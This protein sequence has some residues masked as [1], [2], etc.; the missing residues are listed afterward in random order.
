MRVLSE[1]NRRVLEN[2]K[3]V[4]VGYL[5]A[6]Y[7]TEEKFLEAID[8]CNNTKL[9]IFEI[10]LPSNNPHNDGEIIRRA[11]SA[12][13]CED[14]NEVELFKQVK[15]LTQKPIWIMAYHD[16]LI[17]TKK[18]ISLAE[19]GIVDAFVVPNMPLTARKK[20]KE[21]MEKYEVDVLGFTNPDMDSIEMADNFKSFA[22]IYEQLYSGITGSSNDVQEYSH[23]LEMSLKETN[24]V[25]FAGFGINTKEKAKKLIEQGF[26]GIIIGTEMIRQ[27]NSSVD[28]LVNFINEIGRGIGN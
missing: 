8:A 1:L 2:K 4:L 22:I 24:I 5:L 16:D 18:H 20:F 10:G 26:D 14:I 13:N 27:L 23:M 12:V 6:G 17:K 3:A 21:E 7:P 15:R 28:N 11:H 25:K 19:A 9:D